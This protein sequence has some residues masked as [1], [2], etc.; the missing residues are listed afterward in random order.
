[1]RPQLVFLFIAMPVATLVAC[2]SDTAPADTAA[3]T[4][5]PNDTTNT[6]TGTDTSPSDTTP[7]TDFCTA[8]ADCDGA[9][10]ICDCQGL[11]V[12]PTGS[13]CTEDR[14]CGVPNWC[15]PCT[16]HCEPQVELCDPCQDSRGC[17]DLGLCLPYESGGSFCGLACVTDVG[18]PQGYTCLDLGGP[19]KQCVARSGACEDL[20]LCS[21]DRDCP[22]GQICNAQT[23]NC[24]PGCTEDGQCQQGTVCVSARCVP[25]CGGDGDCVAPATCQGGKCKI[26]GACESPA[27]CPTPETYCDRGTGQC[28]PGCQVDADCKD[29]GKV[30]KSN[31]CI[32]KG[33]QHNFECAFGRVCNKGNGQCEPYPTSEPHCA[34]CNAESE[35]NPSCPTPNIC[36]RFQDDQQQPLGDFCLVQCKDDPIDRCP[37]GWQCQRFEDPES[38]AEQFFCARPCYIPPVSVP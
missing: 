38:G 30:C 25:P 31:E 36:V 12:V 1:M 20:G 29:A 27:D 22:L 8:D 14:N 19:G 28:A 32:D 11:C 34:T 37:S 3:D 7:A 18:C 23:K 33:C 9:G 5:P 15:N 26:P 2:G 10:E 17:K 13:A 4:S 6:D 35:T 16:K 21:A 24:G